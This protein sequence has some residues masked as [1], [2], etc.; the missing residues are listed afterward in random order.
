MHPER[1]PAGG[2]W[3]EGKEV[4]QLAEVVNVE[5]GE[6]DVVDH[7]QRHLHRE[8]VAQAAGTKSKKKRLPLPSST[9]MQVAAW[10]RRGGN[11]QLPTKVIRISSLPSSSDVG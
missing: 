11:G 1:L 9:M 5:V 7:L 3:G 2:P 4:G 8:Y 10:F 6:E